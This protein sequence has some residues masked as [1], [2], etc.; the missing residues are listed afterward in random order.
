[1]T[2][3]EANYRLALLADTRALTLP[4]KALAEILILRSIYSRPIEEYRAIH[5]EIY[6]DAPRIEEGAQPGDEQQK[7]LEACRTA[8]E[9]RAA[10]QCAAPDRRLSPQAW[11]QVVAAALAAETVKSALAPEADV[12]A[13][14]WLE[15]FAANLA[16]TE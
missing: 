12:P 5:T 8:A 7:V 14:V 9:A 2:Y 6:K 3:N 1:M 16:P 4:A 10:E 15:T 11:E 13:T